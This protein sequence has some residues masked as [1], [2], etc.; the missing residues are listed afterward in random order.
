MKTIKL[1]KENIVI[2]YKILNEYVYLAENA[3]TKMQRDKDYRKHLLGL[4]CSIR[5][6]INEQKEY[7]KLLQKIRNKFRRKKCQ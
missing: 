2:L 6:S 4:G 7:I 3:L 5:K 1:I